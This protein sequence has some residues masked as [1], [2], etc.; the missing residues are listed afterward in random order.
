MYR[1]ISPS[2]CLALAMLCLT[3][4]CA[5]TQSISSNVD[6]AL[7]K[8]TVFYWDDWVRR[9]A[10]QI[11]VSPDRAPDSPPTAVFMPMRMTQQ[12]EHANSIGYNLSRIV[13][14]TWLQNNTLPTLEFAEGAPPYR[15][16]IALAYGRKR[17]ADL[18]I[19]GTINYYKDGGTVGDSAVSI[20]LEIYDV[21]SGTMLWSFGQAALMQSSKVND[22]LLFSTKSRVPSDPVVTCLTA[23]ASDLARMVQAWAYNTPPQNNS[24]GGKAF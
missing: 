3:A 9:G 6:I 15:R 11:F 5:R 4:G 20:A 16:D 8:Q 2:L 22:F 18:V 12:M 19:G 14:Q 17:N 24:G 21:K 13:W 1:F 23:A 10:P 7:N